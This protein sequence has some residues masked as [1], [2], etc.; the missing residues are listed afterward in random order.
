MFLAFT[1]ALTPALLAGRLLTAFFAK[2][3]LFCG[4]KAFLALPMFAAL[5]LTAMLLT[6][7][8]AR[9]L[10]GARFRALTKLRP[11][12]ALMLTRALTPALLT[13]FRPLLKAAPF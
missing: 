6:A 5:L 1:S 9:L 10:A 2:L 3:L 7:F 4:T 13:R 12:L 11:L 8:S